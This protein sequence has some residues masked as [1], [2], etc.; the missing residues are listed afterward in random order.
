MSEQLD[1]TKLI[2]QSDYQKK[3][4]AEKSVELIEDGM[5]IGLGSGSTVY[6][7]LKRLGERVKEGL[8]VKGIPSSKRTAGWADEFGI[9]LTGFHEPMQLDLAIDGADEIDGDLNLI[10]GGG[11]SLVREKIVNAAANRLIIIADKSKMVSHLGESALPVEV[12]PFGWEITAKH[13]SQ[14]GCVTTLRKKK[15]EVFISDNGNY[16]LDCQFDHIANPKSLHESLKLLVGVVE[17][18]LF[19]GMTNQV[20]IGENESIKIIYS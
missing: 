17:T 1:Y 4:A 14:L 2:E 19:I 15:K 9:P 16:I 3:M 12:L 11:G 8:I 10:K 13:I 6:W 5:I 18:G 20:I 7:M